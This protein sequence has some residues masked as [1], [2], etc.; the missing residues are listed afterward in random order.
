MNRPILLLFILLVILRHDSLGNYFTITTDKSSYK[1]TDTLSYSV[2]TQLSACQN[3]QPTAYVYIHAANQSIVSRQIL[4][5]NGE[6]TVVKIPLTDLDSGFYFISVFGY[7]HGNNSKLN[8][9]TVC[10]AVDLPD[11]ITQQLDNR[12]I[13]LIP[14]C[15]KA[16]INFTNQMIVT[17]K[18][19]SGSPVCDKIFLETEISN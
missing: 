11:A 12:M 16:L 17:L 18:S 1:H 5:L 4:L 7:A 10:I 6:H 19:R 9:N 15:G 2:F 13:E 3:T 14:E 8:G